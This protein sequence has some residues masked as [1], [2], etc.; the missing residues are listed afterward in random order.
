MTILINQAVWIA[1]DHSINLE[2]LKDWAEGE[3]NPEKFA[4]FLRRAKL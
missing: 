3:D 4:T 1:N 2:D